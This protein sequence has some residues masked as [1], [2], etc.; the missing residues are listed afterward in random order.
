MNNEQIFKM[1]LKKHRK[2]DSFVKQKDLLEGHKIV[3]IKLA[4]TWNFDKQDTK[5]GS[6][7]WHRM[8]CK[9]VTMCNDLNLEGTI[10]LTKV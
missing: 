8:S 2:Y 4:I 5:E 3:G 10:D 9:W 1:F 7:F 6:I